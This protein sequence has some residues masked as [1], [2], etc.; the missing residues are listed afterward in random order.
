VRG[1]VAQHVLFSHRKAQI[2][3]WAVKVSFD[4]RQ[5]AHT[6]TYMD[7]STS[8]CS[9]QYQLSIKARM[10]SVGWVGSEWLDSECKSAYF[11]AFPQSTPSGIHHPIH[12][13]PSANH[14]CNVQC[15]CRPTPWT[16]PASAAWRHALNS[17][18]TYYQDEEKALLC[19][20]RPT[21]HAYVFYFPWV[22]PLPSHILSDINSMSCYKSHLFLSAHRRQ[23]QRA[24]SH[25][26][27]H[28]FIFPVGGGGIID[29]CTENEV[30][31]DT[32]QLYLFASG[33]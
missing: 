21:S 22:P 17:G 26:F 9:L 18:S 5:F 11:Q 24:D 14:S 27:P 2:R 6:V 3:V 33:K 7:I 29:K 15:P 19:S 13:T 32:V 4:P 10:V 31:K 30:W 25:A 20:S 16:C 28:V 1:D 8:S 12:N 23:E